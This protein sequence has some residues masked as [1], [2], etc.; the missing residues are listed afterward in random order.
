VE[1][2]ILIAVSISL[3]YG[4]GLVQEE[5]SS[6]SIIIR[7]LGTTK[8]GMSAVK[9]VET[10][11]SSESSSHQLVVG[12]FDEGQLKVAP[13]LRLTGKVVRSSKEHKGWVSIELSS[14]TTLLEVPVMLPVFALI[15][16]IPSIISKP[17]RTDRFQLQ[18][19][20]LPA[21]A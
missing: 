11:S 16:V 17:D 15:E 14:N 21:F 2:V 8:E 12:V 19:R 6:E 9:T 5:S 10:E 7:F 13:R 4:V 20:F 3:A 18:L 1:E